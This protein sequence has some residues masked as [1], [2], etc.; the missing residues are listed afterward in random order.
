MGKTTLEI[1]RTTLS[2]LKEAGRKGQTYDKLLNQRITCNATGCEREGLIEL[3]A[4]AGN[5]GLVTLFVCDKC[6]TKFVEKET[7]K[8]ERIKTV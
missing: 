8:E 5:F 6:V 7:Q 2:R 3:K 4:Y 1:D